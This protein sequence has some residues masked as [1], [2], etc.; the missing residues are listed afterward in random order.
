MEHLQA[1]LKEL[2]RIATPNK[3][4]LIHYFREGLRPS[5]QTQ[6]DNWGRNLNA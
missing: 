3:E 5:F 2:N 4:I 1:I 6:L